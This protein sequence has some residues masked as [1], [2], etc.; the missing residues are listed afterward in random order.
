MHPRKR[1]KH[2]AP[3][4]ETEAVALAAALAPYLLS[5]PSPRAHLGS[6]S[7]LATRLFNIL[8]LIAP[9]AALVA[10]PAPEL[11]PSPRARDVLSDPATLGVALALVARFSPSRLPPS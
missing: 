8:P 11:D 7:H 9:L 5:P 3:P 10:S 2:A 4:A 1:K 6:P